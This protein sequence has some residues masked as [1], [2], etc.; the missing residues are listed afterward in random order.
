MGDLIEL[1]PQQAP[2]PPEGEPNPCA[3]RDRFIDHH[4]HDFLLSL[5]LATEAETDEGFFDHLGDARALIR[6][7]PRQR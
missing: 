7:W 6:K 3:V 1:F 2:P 5:Q 4:L